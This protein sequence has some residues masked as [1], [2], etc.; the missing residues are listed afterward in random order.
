M[1]SRTD[2]MIE[3]ECREKGDHPGQDGRIRWLVQ[4]PI[5]KKEGHRSARILFRRQS[6]KLR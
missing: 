1:G 2:T 4:D 3:I 5:A 6:A